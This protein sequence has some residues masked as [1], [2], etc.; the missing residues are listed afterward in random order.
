APWSDA[1]SLRAG[2]GKSRRASPRSRR[3]GCLACACA[4]DRGLYRIDPHVDV[5]LARGQLAL[6]L[7]LFQ[8]KAFR[9]RVKTRAKRRGASRCDA[10]GLVEIARRQHA[11][12]ID[13][14]RGDAQLAAIAFADEYGVH[15]FRRSDDGVDGTRL[16]ALRAA[17]ARI[18]VDDGDFL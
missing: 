5:G 6:A 15:Y 2:G 8:R 3:A 10:F 9:A 11:D 17:D 14:T 4:S 1:D 7:G 16:D 18:L 12:A 13:R